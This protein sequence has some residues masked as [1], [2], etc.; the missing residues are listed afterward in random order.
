MKQVWTKAANRA[1]IQNVTS[2]TTDNVELAK[3]LNKS[4]AQVYDKR[5]QLGLNDDNAPRREPRDDVGKNHH[6]TWTQSDIETL[7]DMYHANWS[8]SEIAEAMGRSI[9]SISTQRKV[10]RLV[11]NEIKPKGKQLEF[12]IAKPMKTDEVK[13]TPSEPQVQG[14][15]R[16]FSFA[17]GLIKY[18]KQ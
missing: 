16:E 8:D 15:V 14:Y 9:D 17:W 13:T 2:G 7:R 12:E 10:Q 1:L 6:H 5:Y 18:K 4:V 3:M 11:R